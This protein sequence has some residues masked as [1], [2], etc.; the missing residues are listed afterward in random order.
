VRLYI[1]WSQ[2]QP[3]PEEW[4]WTVVDSFLAQLTGAEEVWVTVCSSSQ[5]A[6]DE[7]SDFLPSSPANDAERC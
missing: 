6:T 5:W 1:Y 3:E 2:V 7:P 4:D